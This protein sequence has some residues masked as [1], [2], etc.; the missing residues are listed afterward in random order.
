MPS[1]LIAAIAQALNQ[2]GIRY[3]IPENENTYALC[4][5]FHTDNAGDLAIHFYASG[6]Q[7]DIA[8]CILQLLTIPEHRRAY[9]LDVI[10]KL[11]LD[12]RHFRFA[13]DADNDVRV[14]YDLPPAC[15]NSAEVACEMCLRMVKAANQAYLY[16]VT[17]CF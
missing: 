13:L 6:D 15:A 10:N 5:R 14:A 7:P 2:K 12:F 16:F 11:H 1:P 4:V 17:P 8:M 9:A 3:E